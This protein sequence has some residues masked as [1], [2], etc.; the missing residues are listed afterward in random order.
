M[1]LNKSQSTHNI[2]SKEIN[3]KISSEE[4]SS[5]IP[6]PYKNN[7]TY[8]SDDEYK[9]DEENYNLNTDKSNNPRTLDIDGVSRVDDKK[10]KEYKEA[11][12]IF[13]KNGRVDDIDKW[14]RIGYVLYNIDR[15]DLFLEFS[16]PKYTESQINGLWNSC[17]DKH[18]GKKL[19]TIASFDTWLKEDLD[20][21]EYQNF[22]AKWNHKKKSYKSFKLKYNVI[23]P[24]SKYINP[25]LL[26]NIEL[27]TGEDLSIINWFV[28]QYNDVV[29]IKENKNYT[30]YIY[31]DIDAL[32]HERPYDFLQTQILLIMSKTY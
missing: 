15:Y 6:L 19:I 11:L 2:K 25:D 10:T 32:W 7:N 18:C 12:N 29:R 24:L 1:S 5:K 8:E 27:L 28:L 23:N 21:T 26:S 9:S 16:R 14:K 4:L 20:E 30:C 31:H 3:G 13:K 17:L 22:K